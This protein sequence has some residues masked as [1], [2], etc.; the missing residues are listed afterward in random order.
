MSERCMCAVCGVHLGVIFG[1]L[2]VHPV[3]LIMSVKRQMNKFCLRFVLSV[4]M[5]TENSHH[6]FRLMLCF[7]HARRTADV[8]HLIA[9]AGMTRRNANLHVQ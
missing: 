7:M 6:K 1:M 2:F 5:Q 8:L 9:V 3:F 4:Q